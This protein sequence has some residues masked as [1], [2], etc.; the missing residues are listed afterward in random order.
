MVYHIYFAYRISEES[1]FKVF[2]PNPNDVEKPSLEISHPN[3]VSIVDQWL[4]DFNHVKAIDANKTF[5]ANAFWCKI[6]TIDEESVYQMSKDLAACMKG[7]IED[8]P[9]DL[10]SENDE[11]TVSSLLSEILSLGNYIKCYLSSHGKKIEIY[12]EG[13]VYIEKM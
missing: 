3:V 13:Y 4:K 8:I 7:I 9:P 12:R 11:T 6:S 2:H 10:F 5:F 1:Q